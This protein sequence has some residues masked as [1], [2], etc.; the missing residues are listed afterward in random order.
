MP[1]SSHGRT[2]DLKY[3]KRSLLVVFHAVAGGLAEKIDEAGVL[4]KV[5][6]HLLTRFMMLTVL[7]YLVIVSACPSNQKEIFVLPRRACACPVGRW[8]KP[9]CSISHSIA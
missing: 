4:R 6:R 2:R 3:E 5:N 1:I 8:D 7:C 9:C